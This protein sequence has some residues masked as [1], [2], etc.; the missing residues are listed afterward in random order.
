VHPNR[1]QVPTGLAAVVDAGINSG[2]AQN[3]LIGAQHVQGMNPDLREHT[4]QGI[5]R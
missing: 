3:G 5:G 1:P 4:R 2:G